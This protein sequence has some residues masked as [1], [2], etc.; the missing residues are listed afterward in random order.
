MGFTINFNN[1]Q[2]QFAPSRA[3]PSKWAETIYGNCL[4][5]GSNSGHPQSWLDTFWA[6]VESPHWKHEIPHSFSSVRVVPMEG[7]SLASPARCRK[8]NYLPGSADLTP[9]EKGVLTGLGCQ[10]AANARGELVG[11]V[12][13]VFPLLASLA[14]AAE[15]RSVT[16]ENLI[17]FGSEAQA[18]RTALCR[19]LAAD[20]GR[21]MNKMGEWDSAH[22]R[23]QL[24]KL[25]LFELLSGGFQ[26]AKEASYYGSAA[27]APTSEWED[28]LGA[29]A[30]A[31]SLRSACQLLKVHGVGKEN[32]K[33]LALLRA[34]GIDR[35]PPTEFYLILI[36]KILPGLA[37]PPGSPKDL[38]GA[39]EAVVL[40]ALDFLQPCLGR[41]DVSR[42]ESL[43]RLPLVRKAADGSAF[44]ASRF[45]DPRNA[46]FRRLFAGSGNLLPDC[47]SSPSQLAVLEAA[48][49]DHFEALFLCHLSDSDILMHGLCMSCFWSTVKK[50]I[51]VCVEYIIH[52]QQVRHCA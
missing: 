7:G 14:G 1:Q 19:H 23:T 9:E 3:L 18:V 29:L 33:Q 35:L 15:K 16:L 31:G 48:G 47:Y 27:C 50:T 43:K 30:K 4:D 44:P 6:E 36:E 49:K 24:S 38:W 28:E 22:W 42:R 26:S 21:V 11:G 17:S 25:K 45:W 5:G 39:A 41:M 32:Q 40:K 20:S 12:N 46:V 13:T 10:I 51:V 52:T 34:T 37:V 2:G 8:F